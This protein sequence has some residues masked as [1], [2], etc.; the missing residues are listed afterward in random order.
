MLYK[1]RASIRLLHFQ[2]IVGKAV[3]ACLR[4]RPMNHCQKETLAESGGPPILSGT[5]LVSGL[6]R[7]ARLDVC[8]RLICLY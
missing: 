7:P 2:V 6:G 1:W 4:R 3:E 5:S 8:V